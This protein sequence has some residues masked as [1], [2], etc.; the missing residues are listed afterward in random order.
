M[1]FG[2]L[3]LAEICRDHDVADDVLSPTLVGGNGELPRSFDHFDLT[4][5]VDH[6]VT[7]ARSTSDRPS[8]RP[9]GPIDAAEA[10]ATEEGTGQ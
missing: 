10:S 6:D 4:I 2:S 9:R 3:V 8:K 5:R 7:R 1:L